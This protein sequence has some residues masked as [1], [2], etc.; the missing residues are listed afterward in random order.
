MP[1]GGLSEQIL[2]GLKINLSFNWSGFV[3]LHERR[4]VTQNLKSPM[5]QEF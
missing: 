5:L 3:L 1:G 2:S 4:Q